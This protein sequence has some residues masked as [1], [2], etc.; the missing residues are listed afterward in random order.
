MGKMTT[1]QIGKDNCLQIPYVE[2]VSAWV[3]ELD[4]RGVVPG[5]CLAHSAAPFGRG[6]IPL[7]REQQFQQYGSESCQL[8]L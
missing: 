8:K 2:D 4:G 3:S 6:R 7:Y 5:Q 1:M